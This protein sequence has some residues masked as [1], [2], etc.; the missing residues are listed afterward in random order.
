M[1]GFKREDAKLS[2]KTYL[3]KGESVIISGP[4][5]CGKTTLLKNVLSEI[6][7]L[8]LITIDIKAMEPSVRDNLLKLAKVPNF[9]GSKT[10]W[11]IPSIDKVD[12]KFLSKLVQ[13]AVKARAV[14][15]VMETTIAKTKIGKVK[16]YCKVVTMSKPHYATLKKVAIDHGFNFQPKNFHEA[17]AGIVDDRHHSDFERITQFFDGTSRVKVNTPFSFWVLHNARKMLK[18]SDQV[19]LYHYM[20]SLARNGRMDLASNLKLQGRGKPEFPYY[21]RKR[22]IKTKEDK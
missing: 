10:L 22:S 7:G 5:G 11:H 14:I 18:A 17:V 21:L 3:M 9:G 8:K 15:L 16:S 2:L 6:K 19:L 1:A 20:S 4:H 13:V 12:K